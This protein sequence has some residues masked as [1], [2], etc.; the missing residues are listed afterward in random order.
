MTNALWNKVWSAV[1][2]PRPDPS[3]PVTPPAIVG[4]VDRPAPGEVVARGLLTVEGWHMIDG[5]P[6]L[7]VSISANG[8]PVGAAMV[9]CVERPDVAAALGDDDAVG[10]GWS[11]DVDL[12]EIDDDEVNLEVAVWQAHGA[13]PVP[14]PLIPVR[15]EPTSQE[16]WGRLDLPADGDVIVGDVLEVKGW[17]LF[18]GTHVAR[19]EVVVDGMRMG[20]A[21]CYLDRPDLAAPYDHPD[22]P[23]A[24]FEALISFEKLRPRATSLVTVEATTLDGQRWRSPTHKVHWIGSDRPGADHRRRHGSTRRALLDDV[25]RA[26][27]RAIV[28]THDLSY[29]GG[30]LWLLELLRQLKACSDLDVTVVSMGDGPLRSELERLGVTAHVT[31]PCPVDDVDAYEDKVNE[32]ALMICG[33]GAGV[34]LVNTLGVFAA[35]DAAD[36]AGVPAVWA[37]HESFDPACYRYLCWAGTSMHPDVVARFNGSFS[38]AR[39]LVFEARQTAALFDHLCSKEQRFVVDYGVDMNEID[40]YRASVDRAALRHAAGFCEEDVVLAVVGV[41]EPRKAQAAMA[42]A[43]DLLS[44]VHD[45]LQLVLVGSRPTT[46]DEGIRARI[47]GSGAADRVKFVPIV[48]DIYPWYAMADILVCA[49]DIESLPRSILEAMAFGLPVVS[50]DA[51]GIADLISDGRTGWLT[52][53]RDLEGLVGLL[54]LVLRLPTEERRAVGERARREV[55]CRHGDR[56]YGRV[57]GEALRA[58][59]RDPSQDL[60]R[61]FDANHDVTMEAEA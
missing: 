3:E 46:Y 47:E 27:S 17:C 51:F 25:T 60:A 1:R 7:A 14:L 31:A 21:R 52:R 28:F 18:E 44:R 49:S 43:F 39:A 4:C 42:V 26:G 57:L 19:V 15:K 38:S 34:V 11:V 53:P 22:A 45:R 61:F 29:G 41:V 24:G 30:Q 59:I 50:T 23:L 10:S 9:G 48:P 5:R 16:V 33:T 2:E 8:L 12:S 37:I 32:L 54:Q 20:L 13:M 58:L 6:A 55:A 56:S 35:V 40:A 36:R